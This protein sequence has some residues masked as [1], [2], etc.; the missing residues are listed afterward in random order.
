MPP[1]WS[2]GG[3]AIIRDFLRQKASQFRVEFENAPPGVSTT[4]LMKIVSAI[5]RSGA[6]SLP[7]ST[8]RD[9]IA[10]MLPDADA[11]LTWLVNE[12]LLIEDMP[13]RD[14]WEE[15]PVLRPAF[16]RLGDHLIATEVLNGLPDGDLDKA[17]QKEGSLHPWL[18]DAGAIQANQGVLGELAVLTSERTLGFELPDLACSP[19]THDDLARIAIR[20]LVFRNPDSLTSSTARLIHHALR[21]AALSYD[22]MDAVLGCAWR[23]SSI[24]AMWF[25]R[26]FGSA[27]MHDRDAFWCGYLHERFESGGVVKSLMGAADELPL[28]DIEPEVAERWVIVLLWFTAAADRRVKDHATRAATSILTAATSIIPSI[29]ERFID[30]DD[31]EVRERVLLSCYGAML[32]SRNAKI[33]REVASRL[34]QRYSDVPPD[35]DNAAIRDHI[36]CICELSVELSPDASQDIDPEAITKQPAS[37]DWPLDIP[38]DKEV[39][40][41]AESLRFRPDEFHSDFFKYSMGCLRPW[42]HGLSKQDMGKWIAQRVARDFSF[43]GSR[44]EGYDGCMLQK[45][46]GGRGKPVWAERIAKKYAW[47]ALNQLA[48]RLHDHVER[49]LESWEEGR[50]KIPLI[51]PERRKLDPTIPEP[52]GVETTPEHRWAIA[53]PKDL[54]APVT[55][56]FETWI[57]NPAIPTLKDIAQAQPIGKRQRRPIVA[58]LNWDGAEKDSESLSLYRYLW[59]HLQSYLVPSDQ[60]EGICKN[61]RGRSLFGRTPRALSFLYGFAAEYPW[62]AVFDVSEENEQQEFP[63]KV[64]EEA[65]LSAVLAWSEVVSEWEYD[66]SRED[67]T[68]N[69]PSRWLFD[70]DLRWDGRGGFA[71]SDGKTVFVDPSFGAGGPPALLADVDFLN[72]RLKAKGLTIILTLTGEKRV[73]AP[74]FG[75]QPNLPRCTFSQVGYLDGTTQRFG[76]P[77]ISIE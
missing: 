46:G 70:R 13:I 28:D 10:P 39:E 44:S 4:C 9:L 25:H 24:D 11:V 15:S 43:H 37:S 33:V 77:L 18:R 76:K 63:Q 54:N 47:I 2:G 71:S 62:G 42:M 58:F 21:T 52:D 60:I 68:I 45:Y 73:H 20:A 7:W 26:F 75:E 57:R 74:G 27:T 38:S 19:D 1:G 65:P 22:A 66:V 35:F 23:Q 64:P 51:L 49:R 29:I 16:E 48:S 36:R 8:A 55:S 53:R 59:I 67:V 30:V 69:V 14:G 72:D 5:A 6:T 41:W 56:D 50:P 32:M 3:S 31:D 12:S 40:G 34:F 17:A 61:L